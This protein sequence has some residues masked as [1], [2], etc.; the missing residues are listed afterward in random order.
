MTAL[1]GWPS[2]LTIT[3]TVPRPASDR[4]NGPTLTTSSPKNPLAP[5]PAG[6][7]AEKPYSEA[8]FLAA[9]RPL[10]ERR[11]TKKDPASVP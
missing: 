1:A 2:K 8:A 3:W 11:A 4:G 6:I 7:D 5:T 10:A 9:I